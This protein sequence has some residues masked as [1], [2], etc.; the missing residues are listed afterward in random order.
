[1]QEG[2]A[3][4][5]PKSVVV[6]CQSGAHRS[7]VLVAMILLAHILCS[8]SDPAADLLEVMSYMQQLRRIVDFESRKDDSWLAP[9]GRDILEFSLPLLRAAAP[10]GRPT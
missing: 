5:E 2:T 7:A 9:N 1:M 4:G 3:L 10:G 6:G 8:S